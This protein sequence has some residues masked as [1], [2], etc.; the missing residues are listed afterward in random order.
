METRKGALESLAE[1]GGGDV[2]ASA[3]NAPLTLP[4]ADYDDLNPLSATADVRAKID[5]LLPIVTPVAPFKLRVCSSIATT[6][7][8][9]TTIRDL[10]IC[11]GALSR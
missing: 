5:L 8:T 1:E 2:P 4:G 7:T 9:T 3:D 10:A 11:S 6:T